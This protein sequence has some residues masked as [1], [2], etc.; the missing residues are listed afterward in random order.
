M[1]K[2]ILIFNFKHWFG[3]RF[4]VTAQNNKF[5]LLLFHASLSCDVLL[6]N[7]HFEKLV[8]TFKM[9]I[10]ESNSWR[11]SKRRWGRLRWKLVIRRW[12]MSQHDELINVWEK[13]TFRQIEMRPSGPA[14]MSNQTIVQCF[15]PSHSGECASGSIN[16]Q[17]WDDEI[18]IK[19]LERNEE[20]VKKRNE[21]IKVGSRKG[22]KLSSM[23]YHV[24][25]VKS[26]TPIIRCFLSAQLFTCDS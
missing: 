9:W 14:E 17:T 26:L 15:Y 5:S 4:Y 6:M 20:M 1:R 3:S 21:I 25:T 13:S 8:D 12:L 11:V 16:S 23:N 19:L 7:C 10:L 22:C 18:K 24:V 2:K